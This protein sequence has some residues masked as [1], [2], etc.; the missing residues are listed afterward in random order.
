MGKKVFTIW[1]YVFLTA[2]GLICLL[3]FI[4]II[5]VSFS[6]A[7]PVSLGEVTLFPKGFTLKSYEFIMANSDFISS[8]YVSVMRVMLGAAVNLL[9]IILTA[10]PLSFEQHKFHARNIYAWFFVMTILFNAGVIPTFLIVRYTGLM[11]S[12]W[13]LIL[14]TALPVFSML[15]V[16]NFIRGLPDELEE[17]AFLDGA[18]YVQTLFRIIL[19]LLKPSLATVALFSIVTHWN[20]WFDGMLYISRPEN[21]PLQTYLRTIIVNPALFLSNSTSVSSKLIDIMNVI[22]TRTIKAAQMVI[23]A[24]PMLV[25]Y[26]FIQKYFTSGLVVGSVKG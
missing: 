8:F 19:P 10:Y 6:S 26:P 13:A 23:A 1:N 14:P 25:V 18:N 4:N 16:M 5:A 17:A 2:A 22:N 12:I 3:P 24:V 7:M 20:S 11:N 9:L 15:V 21:Q